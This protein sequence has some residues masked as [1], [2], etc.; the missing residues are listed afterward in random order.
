MFQWM[1]NRKEAKAREARKVRE[2]REAVL[3]SWRL[4]NNLVLAVFRCGCCDGIR[5]ANFTTVP[6]WQG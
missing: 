3:E 1:R 6:P 5:G 4:N 2:I